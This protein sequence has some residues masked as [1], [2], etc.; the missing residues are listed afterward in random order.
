MAAVIIDTNVLLEDPRILIKLKHSKILV[1]VSIIKELDKHKVGFGLKHRNS[2]EAS[3]ILERIRTSEITEHNVQFIGRS[4]Y[5]SEITDESIIEIA[6]KYNAKIITND[7]NVRVQATCDNIKSEPYKVRLINENDKDYKG[8]SFLPQ[9]ITS[10]SISRFKSKPNHYF[11][12][13]SSGKHKVYKSKNGELVPIINSNYKNV[14]GINALNVYQKMAMDAILDK[15][16]SLVCLHGSAGT[17][18]TLIALACALSLIERG[19]FESVSIG[20][21][22]VSVGKDIGTLPGDAEEKVRPYLT[23]IFDNLEVISRAKNEHNHTD[24]IKELE[25]KKIITIQPTALMR[26]RTLR[27]NLFII[28]EAQNLTI[29]EA[30][31]LI[32]R[33]GENSKI[34][35]LGD[36]NQIDLPDLDKNSNGLDF[37]T[38]AFIGQECFSNITLEKV[39]R[40]KL[41]ELAIKLLKV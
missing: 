18:K 21:T 24:F 35:L 25:E 16:I 9:K 41:A 34:I 39:E 32:T 2:R 7:L 27:N 15:R 29:H 17:G 11:I 22:I 10:K 23:P 38:N 12:E 8:Y 1:P 19:D 20:R 6:K 33:A 30:K 31:T 13:E 4:E 36:T 3:R 37:V 5:T 28:D 40:S 26:G 14:S